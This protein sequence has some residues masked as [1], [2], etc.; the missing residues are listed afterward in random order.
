MRDASRR[1][2]ARCT[3]PYLHGVALAVNAVPDAA[4]VIDAPSCNFFRADA[5]SGRHDLCSTLLDTSGR[6]RLAVTDMHVDRLAAGSGQRLAAL[7]R[8]VAA[9]PGFR[10]V[11]R[12][13]SPVASIIGTDYEAVERDAEAATGTPVVGLPDRSLS[14]DWLDGYED[15][16]A[17]LAE[18]IPLPSPSPDPG[19]VA[20][21]GL[22]LE[23]NEQDHL[24]NVRE[25]RRLVAGIGLEPTAVWLC[26][27]GIRELARVSEAGTILA[28]PGG[29]RAAE[30]LARR[31][32]ASVVECPLPFGPEATAA[33]VR[34]AGEA[35]GRQRE[36]QALIETNTRAWTRAAR[37]LVTRC[38]VDSRWAIGGA[39]D[40]LPGFCDLA[41]S[42]GAEVRLLVAWS[43][44][45][46]RGEGR[47]WPVP[48]LFGV[49]SQEVQEAF[50][51]V[52]GSTDV[53]I[54]SSAVGE[55]LGRV[56]PRGSRGRLDIPFVE[57]GFPSYAHHALHDEPFLGW[58]GTLALLSRIAE[59]A[60]RSE[61]PR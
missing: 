60:R 35:T 37:W 52:A 21:V 24:G 20:L 58:S 33:F 19:K 14:G 7:L 10:V 23:R 12:A 3:F 8:R 48:P 29:R 47:S 53:V 9:D 32:G 1:H 61:P 27:E 17:A 51:D 11:F 13:A 54:G 15:V 28:L 44:R 42:V 16:L 43:L 18:R 40:I 46:P 59:A 57:L 38:L 55:V 26:G 25:M 49:G 22:R 39:P 56:R 34:A 30:T 41:E 31:T 5:I 6:H 50:R 36:G 2:A 45:P 4:L